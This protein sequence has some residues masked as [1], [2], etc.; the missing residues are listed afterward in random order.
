MNPKFTNL[1]LKLEKWFSEGVL[2]VAVLLLAVIIGFFIYVRLTMLP[3]LAAILPAEQTYAYGVFSLS[4]YVN[5]KATLPMLTAPFEGFLKKPLNELDFI[6]DKVGMAF[7]DEKEVYFIKIKSQSK[8]LDY[9][10][11]IK[12]S[13]EALKFDTFEN[14]K[15]Y[16]YEKSFPFKFA[17]FGGIL[18]LSYKDEPLKLMA[19][20]AHGKLENLKSTNNFSNVRSRLP[21]FSSGFFYANL[22]SSRLYIAQMFATLGV[23]EPGFLESIFQL[24]PS[25]GATVKMEANGWY[26]ETFT[27]V[28]KSKIDNKG[29]FRY[30]SKYEHKFLSYLPNDYLFE[31]GGHSVKDQIFRM[32]DLLDSLHSSA[33]LIFKS[34]IQA[35]AEK[36]FGKGTS[37]ENDIYPILNDE[38]LF[39][40]NPLEAKKFTFLLELNPANSTIAYRLKDTFVM[41]YKYKNQYE[42]QVT[43][44]G[45]TFTETRADLS[46]LS[47]IEKKYDNKLYYLINAGDKTLAAIYIDDNFLLLTENEASLLSTLDIINGKKEGRSLNK[48]SSILTGSD[49]LSLLNLSMLKDDNV[50]KTLLKDFQ[51]VATTRKVFDDG[52]FTRHSLLFQ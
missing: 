1:V 31:W 50:L 7:I 25:F 43:V 22:P 51:S 30:D 9:F 37:L 26:L 20:V 10:E 34:S 52:I 39:A 15:I 49:E 23:T 3:N 29:F 46:S 38:Y 2:A 27:A 5:S 13:D 21:Y 28:D 4:D 14:K 36:Y 8:A 40:W 42:T 32:T 33:S 45:K 17:F 16:F 6:G 11:S 48:F 12:A 44:D 47:Q 18:A 24:F 19:S 35:A 41:N